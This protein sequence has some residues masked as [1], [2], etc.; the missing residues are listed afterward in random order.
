M[1]LAS[2][3]RTNVDNAELLLLESRLEF[4]KQKNVVATLKGHFAGQQKTREE[5]RLCEEKLQAKSA[6][7][8]ADMAERETIEGEDV[9]EVDVATGVETKAEPAKEVKKL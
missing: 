2:G 4:A 8:A 6:E 7:I 5:V 1:E 3:E 9:Q